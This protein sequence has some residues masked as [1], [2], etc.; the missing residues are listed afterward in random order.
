MSKIK[1]IFFILIFFVLGCEKP[2]L[3]EMERAREAVFR[4]EN[5]SDAVRYAN[6]TLTRAQN[7]LRHMQGEAD[8]K[9]YDSAKSL[10]EEAIAAAEKAI[11]DG[12]EAA[13]RASEDSA[14]PSAITAPAAPAVSAASPAADALLS[15]LRAEIE[16]TTANVSAARYALLDLDYDSLDRRI[17]NAHNAADLA[18]A[19]QSAGR[20]QDA[21][22]RAR[23]VRMD[24]A[25]IN[26]MVANAAPARKK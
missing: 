24:L 15:G 6:P 9:L 10:A 8:S 18:E 1:Y 20:T 16:E 25:N 19:D 26:Q 2:P 4:A 17:I 12:R 21:A 5:D 7:A 22:N 14:V 23:D 13:R 11:I 3:A